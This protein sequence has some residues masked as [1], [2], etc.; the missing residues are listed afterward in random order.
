[1]CKKEVTL[2]KHEGVKEGKGLEKNRQ[3]IR[4]GR[5]LRWGSKIWKRLRWEER[6]RP[7]DGKDHRIARIQKWGAKRMETFLFCGAKL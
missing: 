5:V 6:R 3:S 1:V 2:A 4:Q 7:F